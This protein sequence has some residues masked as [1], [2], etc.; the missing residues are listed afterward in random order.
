MPRIETIISIA[1]LLLLSGVLAGRLADRLGV[2]SL[3]LFLAVGMLA[4]SEGIGGIAFDSPATTQAVGTVCLPIELATFPAA[5]GIEGTEAIFNVI[6]FIV[7]T[8]VV[9]QGLSLVPAARR[10]GVTEEVPDLR[11]P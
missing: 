5:Y 4:G 11:E 8:S 1:G 9:V 10:L 6:F 2:P 3:L 7:L